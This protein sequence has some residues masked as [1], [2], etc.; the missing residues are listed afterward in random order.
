MLEE[1]EMYLIRNIRDLKEKNIET[2]TVEYEVIADSHITG[3]LEFGP[4]YFTI[5]EYLPKKEGEPRKLCLR[6]KS[7]AQLYYVPGISES[8]KEPY[9]HGGS[10]AD[11]FVVLASLFLRRRLTLSAKV[12]VNDKPEII[13][14]RIVPGWIDRQLI[15]P[16]NLRDLEP[17]FKKLENFDPRCH[18]RFILAVKFYHQAIEII[19]E[20]PILAYLNLVSAIEVLC[21]DF[22]IGV[23]TLREIDEKLAELIDKVE[24]GCLR[25]ELEAHILKKEKFIRRRF[26]SFILSYLEDSFWDEPRP[27][28]GLIG[29]ATLPTLLKRIYDQRSK[30]LHSGDPF[31]P[32]IIS[33]DYELCPACSVSHIGR[34]WKPSEY[35]PTVHFFEKLVNHVLK[36]YISRNQT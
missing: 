24:D 36:N 27:E 17:Y 11:E 12:R 2:V 25:G 3:D 35:I 20:H 4:Y 21:Q 15:E 13:P 18:Q 16:A 34:V 23:V 8:K 30:T 33:S 19:E 6:I 32:V 22:D 26:A 14:T 1:G 29:P 10:L 7:K 28:R 9:Y 31:P 5:W